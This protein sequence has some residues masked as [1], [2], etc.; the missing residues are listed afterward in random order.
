MSTTATASNLCSS[1]YN[2][3]KNFDDVV[4]E[5]REFE[6]DHSSYVGE[7]DYIVNAFIVNCNKVVSIHHDLKEVAIDIRTAVDRMREDGIS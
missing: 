6:S 4:R 5:I 2:A 3:I 1:L 7:G